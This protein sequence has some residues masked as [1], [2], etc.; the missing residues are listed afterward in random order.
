M[1]EDLIFPRIVYRGE[2]DTLGLGQHVG[3]D[4]KIV[5]ETTR[6]E[7]AEDWD[8]KKKDGWRLTSQLSKAAE[9]KK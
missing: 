1:A 5:G 8:V 4:G 6:C 3:A 2:P 7:S 9:A